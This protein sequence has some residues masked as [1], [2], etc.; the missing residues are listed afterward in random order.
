MKTID[1]WQ[2][3]DLNMF[4]CDRHETEGSKLSLEK[5]SKIDKLEK[6]DPNF[7]ILKKQIIRGEDPDSLLEV[8]Q[9][10]LE[11]KERKKREVEHFFNQIKTLQKEEIVD[12]KLDCDS[13][14][15][16]IETETSGKRKIEKEGEEKKDEKEA[17]YE[18]ILIKEEKVLEKEE[19]SLEKVLEKVL[20]DEEKKKKENEQEVDNPTLEKLSENVRKEAE[21]EKKKLLHVSPVSKENANKEDEEKKKMEKEVLENIILKVEEEEV[22]MDLAEIDIEE[23]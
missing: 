9:I 1:I 5:Q 15:L 14:V 8:E 18:N 19:R 21:E 20:E 7:E 22:D 11:E 16:L 3:L 2:G 4:D 23:V 10:R 13:S 17:L 12:E 6:S